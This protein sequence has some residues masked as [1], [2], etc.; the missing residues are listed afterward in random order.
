MRSD[1]KIQRDVMEELHWE[2]ILNEAE[3]GVAVTDGVVTLSGHINSY[4]K[5]NKAEQAAKRVKGVKAVAVDLDVQLSF[6]DNDNDTEIAMAIVHAFRWNTLIPD[7]Q[8]KVKVEM[9]WVTLEGEVEWQYQK[10]AAYTAV[11]VITGVK[12]I[13]NMI[14]I[15]PTVD[16][17]IIKENI[18]KALERNADIDAD[19]ISVSADGHQVTLKGKAASWLKRNLI[20]RAAWS[21]PGV[22]EVIDEIEVV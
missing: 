9:G 11:D 13:Y 8:L 7:T 4:T 15:R 17:A 5:K 22:M 19:H 10:E 16:T 14:L 12:G 6:T 18:K 3:I 20:S 2:P 21:S 1:T